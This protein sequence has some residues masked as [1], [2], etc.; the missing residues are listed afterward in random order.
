MLFRSHFREYQISDPKARIEIA[1][2]AARGSGYTV[3]KFIR[4]FEIEDQEALI[5]VAKIAILE[6]GERLL[7]FSEGIK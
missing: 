1:E 6:D 7:F 2:I 3:S 4:Y 5:R